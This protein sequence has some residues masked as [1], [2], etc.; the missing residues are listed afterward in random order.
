MA[1]QSH[2]TKTDFK[3]DLRNNPQWTASLNTGAMRD[4]VTQSDT[5]ANI[6]KAL[7]TL[8]LLPCPRDILQKSLGPRYYLNY[9]GRSLQN[10]NS[11]GGLYAIVM[12]T[13]IC[14]CC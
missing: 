7:N 1:K 10:A 8:R 3:S 6:R 12:I 5:S 9:R 13:Q 2:W 11:P 14:I 4:L